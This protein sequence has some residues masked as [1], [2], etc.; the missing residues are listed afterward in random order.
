MK[1]S[2]TFSWFKKS[3]KKLLPMKGDSVL[4]VIFKLVAITFVLYFVLLLLPIVITLIVFF[5]IKDI[6]YKN[7]KFKTY[8][9][10]AVV[11]F[12]LV[13]TG[14]YWNSIFV[15][16]EDQGTTTY[17]S[18]NEPNDDDGN[19]ISDLLK[20][21]KNKIEEFNENLTI[22]SNYNIDVSKYED[23]NVL[24]VTDDS[25]S[26]VI[27]S[28]Y[29]QVNSFNDELLASIDE[30]KAKVYKVEEVV[31]GDTLKITYNGV[32]ESVRLIGIDTPETIHPTE[33]VQC[34][35]QEASQKMKDLVEGK[36]VRIM[37]DNSQGLR[38]KYGRLLLYVWV[39]DVFVNKQMIVDGYAYEYTYST[40]YLY[41]K[42]F[43]EAQ[44]KAE[45]SKTGLWGDICACEKKEIDR[46][47]TSCNTSTTTYQN[48]D[49]STYTKTETNTACTNGCKVSVPTVPIATPTPKY[50]CD[51]SKACEDI[52]TCEE[53]YYQLNTCGC[54]ARDRDKDGIPCESLCN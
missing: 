31:D 17:S 3:A 5:I 35:G 47:C 23:I 2:G 29:S 45:S 22:A 20:E 19:D 39:G 34:F 41:Q 10:T 27:T 37:F 36:D 11:I 51:C 43:K 33:A 25:S 24:G 1:K 53:A 46:K 40:P 54:S 4:G 30:A 28:T 32:K 9:L 6:E 15:G 12:G 48:W 26:D 49:C 8:S 14:F 7:P 18:S 38:D 13:F 42:E 50:T 21:T 52:S 44:S 16:T